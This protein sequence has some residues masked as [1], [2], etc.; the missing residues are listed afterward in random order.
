MFMLLKYGLEPY[1]SLIE[2]LSL[3]IIF[4]YYGIF[5]VVIELFMAI[6]LWVKRTFI[7]ALSLTATLTLFGVLISLYS[8]V[9][10]FNSECGCGLLGDNEYGLL[11]QKMFILFALLILYNGRNKLFSNPENGGY[12]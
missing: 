9:F 4:R 11:A 1:S 2:M 8:L 7:F 3:P 5:A 6:G 10:K 12:H